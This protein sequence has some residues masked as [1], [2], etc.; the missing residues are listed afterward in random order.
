[1]PSRQSCKSICSREIRSS[2]LKLSQSKARHKHY[3]QIL[4]LKIQINHP[5]SPTSARLRMIKEMK[6]DLP[7]STR[8]KTECLEAFA[9]HEPRKRTFIVKIRRGRQFSLIIAGQANW[10]RAPRPLTLTM[11]SA[12]LM[13]PLILLVSIPCL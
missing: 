3:S 10:K 4:Y 8:V 5:R 9:F 13:K 6:K 1:V 11:L 12:P 2:G 7:K